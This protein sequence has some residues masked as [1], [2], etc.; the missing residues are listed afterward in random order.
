VI[1]IKDRHIGNGSHYA[2]YNAWSVNDNFLD[3]QGAEPNQGRFN[4]ALAQGTPAVWTTNDL[5]H[6]AFSPFNA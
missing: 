3:W 1:P 2:K 5:N 4:D 6:P